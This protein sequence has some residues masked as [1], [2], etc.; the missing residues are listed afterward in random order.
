MQD[1]QA[2]NFACHI[3]CMD[4]STYTPLVRAWQNMVHDETTMYLQTFQAR[5]QKGTPPPSNSCL[6]CCFQRK[7]RPSS[8]HIVDPLKTLWYAEVQQGILGVVA[9]MDP[10]SNDIYSMLELHSIMVQ[11]IKDND[12]RT[13]EDA[14]KA[15]VM[16]LQTSVDGR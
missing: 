1:T 5:G 4:Q 9:E 7:R 16:F 6:P 8:T 14:A 12:T 10:H 15:I 2:A 13:V 11:A 3:I